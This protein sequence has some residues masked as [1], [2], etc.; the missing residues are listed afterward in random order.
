MMQRLREHLHP[1][2][3]EKEG[4]AIDGFIG[5]PDSTRINRSG[6]K[7]FINRRPVRL[8]SLNWALDRAYEEF[9]ERDRY[10]V[11]VL[12]IDIEPSAIDVNVHPA[13]R[14]VRLLK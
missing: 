6:Q 13:K 7:F 1:I 14:E 8:I 11:A 4:V 10:P 3:L 9:K 5:T 2:H 12:F